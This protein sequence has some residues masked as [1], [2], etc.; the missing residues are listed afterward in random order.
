V[1]EETKWVFHVIY[2][3]SKTESETPLWK[4]VSEEE[5]HLENR[6]TDGKMKRGK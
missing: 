4:E 2:E 3:W 6:V 5:G 1:W